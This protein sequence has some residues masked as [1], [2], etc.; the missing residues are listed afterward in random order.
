MTGA[1]DASSTRSRRSTRTPSRT[2]IPMTTPLVPG[3]CPCGRPGGDDGFCDEHAGAVAFKVP[4]G[5]AGEVLPAVWWH[6]PHPGPCPEGDAWMIK[7][8]AGG[9]GEALWACAHRS[10]DFLGGSHRLTAR[11]AS[12]PPLCIPD[13]GG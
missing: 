6:W 1:S 11:R 7:P 13:A 3:V 2:E 4:V 8:P 9:T 5:P 10:H 12:S